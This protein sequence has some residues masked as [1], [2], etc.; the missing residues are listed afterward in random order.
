MW[1]KNRSLEDRLAHRLAGGGLGY[2][3]NPHV[4]A[5]GVGGLDSVLPAGLGGISLPGS[6]EAT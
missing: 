3:A 1:R 4:G 2:G 6:F 5:A